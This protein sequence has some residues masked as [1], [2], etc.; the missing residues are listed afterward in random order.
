MIDPGHGGTNR[1]AFG[2]AANVS[3]KHLALSIARLTM[4]RLRQLSPAIRVRLTRYQDIYVTLNQRVRRANEAGAT[5]FVSIHLNAS[6][7]HARQGFETFV[8]SREASNQEAQRLAQVESE[9]RGQHSPRQSAV[10]G[11]LADLRFRAAQR[12]SLELAKAIEAALMI[13]R[14]DAPNRG[15]K[16]APFDVLMGL[17]MPAVL[18]EVG[19][20][21]HP[22]EGPELSRRRTQIAVADA[23]AQGIAAFLKR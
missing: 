22:E 1:G 16:Q 17:R 21:D 19:F 11:I 10:A 7:T 8:L 18:V 13:A 6:P 2:A 20:I 4:R 12:R 14:R 3:E 5:L 23:L 9:A 15:V